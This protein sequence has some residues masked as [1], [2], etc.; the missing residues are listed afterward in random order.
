MSCEIIV[1]AQGFVFVA[2][3]VVIGAADQSAIVDVAN[4]TKLN[5]DTKH[6]QA[7]KVLET[8]SVAPGM[9]TDITMVGVRC[10]RIWGTD[11]GLGQLVNGP[12]TETKLDQYIPI[13]VAPLHSLV[14]RFAVS[15]VWSEHLTL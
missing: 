12:R 6:K 2:K 14:F 9:P 1:L 8:L 4:I 7:A 11:Q 10:I 5:Q 3:E 15:D 13:V